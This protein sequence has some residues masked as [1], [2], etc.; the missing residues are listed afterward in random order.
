MKLGQVAV[1][2]AGYMGGGIAQVLARHGHRVV[3]VDV[4]AE[5]AGSARD[6]LHREARAYEERGLW[7]RGSADAVDAHLS[8]SGSIADGVAGADY[9][10][11]A[12]PEDPDLKRRILTMISEAARTETIIATNTSSIPLASLRASVRQPLLAVHW[13]NPAPFLPLVELAGDD[14]LALTAVEEMLCA[15]GKS[16]VRVPDVPGFLG[17]RL[18][19]ALYKE[20]ALIVEEGLATPE[21]V[22]QVASG[23]FGFRL[24]FFGPF[25]VGDVAGLDVYAASF[26]TLAETY[27]DRFSAP[28]SLTEHVSNGDLGMKTGGGVTGIDADHRTAVESYRD[29]A[30][31]ALSRLLEELGPPPHHQT[32]STDPPSEVTG[33]A[34]EQGATERDPQGQS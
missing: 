16:P 17:N 5:R 3:L 30:F 7:P 32:G 27:G 1:V 12:V 24:P 14:D 28:A 20:A 10:T 23:S 25:A 21:Q 31:V 13:F 34:A 18:Q 6:R 33:C 19:F 9:V 8:A 11:E 22:D 15:A 26:R 4:D 2:G 29:R